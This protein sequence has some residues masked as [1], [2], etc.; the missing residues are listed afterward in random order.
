MWGWQKTAKG[1]DKMGRDLG[2][3]AIRGTADL[4]GTFRSICAQEGRRTS[5][6]KEAYPSETEDVCDEDGFTLSV[7]ENGLALL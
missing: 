7:S 2:K 6:R 1:H 5:T 3:A 4:S